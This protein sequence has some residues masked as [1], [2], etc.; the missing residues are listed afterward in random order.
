MS[1][2]SSVSVRGA[3]IIFKSREANNFLLNN[4]RKITSFVRETME[5]FKLL[6]LAEQELKDKI[7]AEVITCFQELADQPYTELKG[8]IEKY[9]F[10]NIQRSRGS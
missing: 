7:S 3:Y 10:G 5:K 9:I 8:C 4:G 1:A 6:E 2:I